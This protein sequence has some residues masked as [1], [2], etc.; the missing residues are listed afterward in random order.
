[1]ISPCFS[2]RLGFRKHR[3]YI[4]YRIVSFYLPCVFWHV[5]GIVFLDY[6]NAVFCFFVSCASA[7]ACVHRFKQYCQGLVPYMRCLNLDSANVFV[8]LDWGRWK[9][10]RPIFVL[11]HN[12]TTNPRAPWGHRAAKLRFPARNCLFARVVSCL[13]AAWW[14][15][16][17]S[18]WLS[19]GS[20]GL[21]MSTTWPSSFKSKLSLVWSQ[22][23]HQF[24][25][26][27][28]ILPCHQTDPSAYQTCPK[29]AP[30]LNSETSQTAVY[31]KKPSRLYLFSPSCV[32]HIFDD[33]WTPIDKVFASKSS[34][35]CILIALK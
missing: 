20:Q 22:N 12:N 33:P 26:V 18:W 14:S 15:A 28:R 30:K 29:H 2:A 34:C 27:S 10:H 5:L 7:G 13:L 17:N 21:A 3:L 24:P 16:A 31:R 32:I 8:L 9:R 25:A 1:M 11:I 35:S 23:K 6:N 4:D 19:V